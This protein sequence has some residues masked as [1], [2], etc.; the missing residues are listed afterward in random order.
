MFCW[1]LAL[2][3]NVFQSASVS[4]TERFLDKR[5]MKKGLKQSVQIMKNKKNSR[6]LA[7][8][9]LDCIKDSKAKKI[10]KALKLGIC[11]NNFLK[12]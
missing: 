2:L 1:T 4:E 7:V 8:P 12:I 6:K 10:I 11:L 3:K 9:Q 5:N